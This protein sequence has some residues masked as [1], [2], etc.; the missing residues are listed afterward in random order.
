[1]SKNFKSIIL[2]LTLLII[3]LGCGKF[4]GKQVLGVFVDSLTYENTGGAVD[5]YCNAV[6]QDGLQTKLFV[7][8]WKS[9]EE[10]KKI[11]IN[12]S[13]KMP[14]Q[15]VV[16]IGDIPIAMIRDA[17]HLTS[18]FKIDQRR[19]TLE[20]T[21]VPSDRFYDDFDLKFDFI[22]QDTVNQLLF[23][24]SLNHESP[25]YVNKDI[26]SGRI[27]SPTS[28]L[29]KYKIIKDYLLL[30]SRKK[31]ENEK[32]DNVL[33]FLG[34]GYISESLAAKENLSFSLREQFPQLF[35]SSG[36]IKNL[37]HSMD[38][39]MKEI[40]LNELQKKELDMAI[41]HAHGGTDTQYM[42][43]YPL[44]RSINQNVDAIKLF[45]RNKM[46]YAKRREK[47]VDEY[48]NNYMKRYN[49]PNKWFE[50]AFVDSVIIADSL[51]SAKLDIYSEDVKNISPQAEL[52]IFDQC[53]N[54]SFH[55][56]PYIAGNYVFGNGETIVGIANSVNVKQNIWCNELLGILNYGVRVGEW[57][58]FNNYLESHIIG[59]PTFHFS[60]SHKIDISK[61]LSENNKKSFYRLLKNDDPV[62]RTLAIRK[63]FDFEKEKFESKLINI[64]NADISF[65]VRMEALKCMA[66]IHIHSE[67]F[68]NI[69]FTTIKDPSEYIRRLSA[70]WMGQIGEDKYLQPLIETI[71]NDHSER[72]VFSAKNSLAFMCTDSATHEKCMA[73]VEK[74]PKS[75]RNKANK[76]INNLYKHSKKRAY[77]DLIVSI[78]D[79][80]L[81]DK[82]RISQIRTFRSYKFYQFV[83]ELL[84]I[85]KDSEEKEN[86]RVAIIEAL[87][88]YSFSKDRET[89]INE[90]E[91]IIETSSNTTKVS[92]EIEKTIKRL[93]SYP[94][95]SVSF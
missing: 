15:G 76:Q 75:I 12:L 58:K 66:N 25:Q 53:F 87:G 67:K 60:N 42:L 85:A 9:P 4:N 61:L 70:I 8:N 91:K 74:F 83:P 29:S 32:L 47:S 45:L 86:V 26:Y 20:K 2:F 95:N 79:K 46:R 40:I 27:K 69:L 71:F 30:V 43:G 35:Y 5:K 19:Y 28:D 21:S 82:K 59:D 56:S 72:V 62:L 94:N 81:S 34:H 88:W 52:I 57:H 17:Q 77:D 3:L 14:L 44:S 23:Y 48:K 80:N 41:F 11:I 22:E 33:T 54:G 64:Y 7:Q 89:I 92:K 55:K 78:Q 39:N 84:E 18:A 31:M 73:H 63:I 65:N 50:G 49:I 1:M 68:E 51:Y 13:D 38:D 16:F 93:K 6:N 24:Y 37:Y 10:I 36:N 90:F